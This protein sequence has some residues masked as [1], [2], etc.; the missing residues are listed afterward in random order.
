MINHD[1][2]LTRIT[3]CRWLHMPYALVDTIVR[4]SPLELLGT[5]GRIVDD[6]LRIEL[7]AHMPGTGIAVA[8]EAAVE[9]GEVEDHPGPIP[10]VRVPLAWRATHGQHLFP[11]MHAYFEAFPTTPTDTELAIVGEYDPPLG[12]VGAVVDHALMH[13]VASE[14]VAELLESIALEIKH[15]RRTHAFHEVHGPDG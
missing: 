8:A 9:V 6:E 7:T 4:D 5:G 11:E 1:P 10:S 2:G 3:E 13:K 14:A 12:A 15:R